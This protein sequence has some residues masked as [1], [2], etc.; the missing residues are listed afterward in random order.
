MAPF[1][2]HLSYSIYR[3]MYIAQMVGNY[4]IYK[5]SPPHFVTDR[6]LKVVW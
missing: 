5:E 2:L 6:S 1:K 4:S 3:P